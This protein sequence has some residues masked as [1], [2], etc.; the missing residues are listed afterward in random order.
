MAEALD[1]QSLAQRISQLLGD[2]V[3]ELQPLRGGGNNC[4]YRVEIRSGAVYVAKHYASGSRRSA[5]ALEREWRMLNFLHE[6]GIDRVP[7]PIASEPSYR[8]TLFSYIEG[9]SG[10]TADLGEHD[11]QQAADFIRQLLSLDRKKPAQQL[12]LASEACFDIDGLITAI[13]QRRD[14]LRSLP[15]DIPD[16]D[17]LQ[18]FL[19]AE[20]DPAFDRCCAGL[21][22][23][24][25]GYQLS[26]V[27]SPSDFGFHNALKDVDGRWHFLDF[28][29]SGWDGFEKMI[30]DFLLHPGM[31]LAV[32]Q[33][34][35]LLALVAGHWPDC[36]A[37][38]RMMPT[39]YRLCALKWTLILLNEFNPDRMRQRMLANPAGATPAQ[40]RHEQ[41]LKAGMAIEGLGQAR[42]ETLFG[43]Q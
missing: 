10:E 22:K 29:F 13:Q 1:H 32:E 21:K 19:G 26:R 27:L 9:Q 11:F 6:A 20:F 2:R 16:A 42:L 23:S 4:L 15:G 12:G 38:W 41:L 35:R 17:R 33:Q 5:A 31:Q 3:T 34:G 24:D 30:A 8:L 39:I 43:E 40:R 28:E 18:N 7:R 25:S 37:S 36:E 14:F